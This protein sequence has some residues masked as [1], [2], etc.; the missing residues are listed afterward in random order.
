MIDGFTE[1]SEDEFYS[2][3]GCKCCNFKYYTGM[4]DGKR[5]YST[6]GVKITHLRGIERQQ[7]D[8]EIIMGVEVFYKR[9]PQ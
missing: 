8:I 6:N 3:L 5:A 1:I 7:V 2:D 4:L 9:K